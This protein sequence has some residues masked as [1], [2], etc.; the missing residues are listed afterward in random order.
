MLSDSDS[1]WAKPL[2]RVIRN[3]LDSVRV[4]MFSF[5]KYTPIPLAFSRRTVSRQSTVFRA[6]RER[7]FVMIRSIWPR[8]QAVIIFLNSVRFFMLV[9]EIPSSAAVK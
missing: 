4:L 2:N 9:P 6:K 3:S 7:D 5:S 8:L 1:A